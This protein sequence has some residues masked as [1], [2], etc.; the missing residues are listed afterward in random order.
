MK[1]KAKEITQLKSCLILITL[2]KT[3]L[4]KFTNFIIKA[5]SNIK[6]TIKI[7][8]VTEYNKKNTFESILLL[9]FYL[10]EKNL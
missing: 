8:V 9:L 7:I 1:V 5:V 2:N 3:T 4:P 10:I 6:T